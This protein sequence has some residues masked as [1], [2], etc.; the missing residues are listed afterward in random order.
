MSVLV[1]TARADDLSPVFDL[2]VAFATSGRP[3]RAG[4]EPSFRHVLSAD[5]A[6]LLVAT[7]RGEIVGYLL[8]FVH[9]TFYADA[10]VAWVEEVMVKEGCRRTGAGSALMGAFET[11]SREQAAT[12]VSLATR[13]A[14]AFY[15]ALSYEESA[16]YFRKRLQHSP[17]EDAVLLG[18]NL[19]IPCTQG[20][21]HSCDALAREDPLEG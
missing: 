10:P 21:Y 8:G 20:Y 14:A 6:L 2:A 5:A 12:F 4:F 17:T 16:T 7:E 11:W 9:P 3:T 13:R 15:K 19:A 1:R 18:G